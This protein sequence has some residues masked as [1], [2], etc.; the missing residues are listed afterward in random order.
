MYY[1]SMYYRA[2]TERAILRK[3]DVIIITLLLFS[4]ENYVR[5]TI[6]TYYHPRARVKIRFVTQT[7][8]NFFI[9]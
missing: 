3:Q 8:L 4:T 6:S 7:F 5:N 2:T 1:C 9:K